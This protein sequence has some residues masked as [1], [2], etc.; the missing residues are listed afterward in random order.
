MS[1]TT[2]IL[3]AMSVIVKDD[4]PILYQYI[5]GKVRSKEAAVMRLTGLIAPIFVGG[6]GDSE[7]RSASRKFLKQKEIDYKNGLIEIKPIHY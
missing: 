5:K 3:D 7:L 1:N 6:Y 2:I 4:H